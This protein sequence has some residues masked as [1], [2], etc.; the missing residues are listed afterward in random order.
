MYAAC[1]G[2]NGAVYAKAQRNEQHE[3]FDPDPEYD[4]DGGFDPDNPVVY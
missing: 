3:Q 2:E 1:S 4:P